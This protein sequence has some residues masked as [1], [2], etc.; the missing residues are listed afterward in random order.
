MGIRDA[1]RCASGD[2]HQPSTSHR[3]PQ[4]RALRE[5]AGWRFLLCSSKRADLY[6][7]FCGHSAAC[8]NGPVLVGLRSGYS[9]LAQVDNRGPVCY[10]YCQM[11]RDGRA[12]YGD[13]LENHCGQS[14]SPGVRIPLPPPFDTWGGAGVVDRGRLLSGCRVKSSTQGSNPCLPACMSL[15]IRPKSSDGPAERV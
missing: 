9:G 4:P 1:E 15:E 11:G 13:G 6:R 10:T 2:S 8:E 7:D 14:R 3:P 5:Q 12:D